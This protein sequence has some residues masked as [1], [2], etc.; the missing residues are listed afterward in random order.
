ME[1]A[2][3]RPVTPQQVPLAVY[4]GDTHHWT[5]TV[6][7]ADGQPIDLT[8]ATGRAEIRARSGGTVLAD[9]DCAV[10]LPN[11]IELLL[12]ADR[13]ATLPGGRFGWDLQLMF[14]DDTVRTIV[15]GQV[16]VT[17]DITDSVPA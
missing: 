1:R 9:I 8:G 13:S 12:P 7:A 14:G 2:A 6:W 10:T 5:V 4:C 11:T 3:G 15:A 17:A 16:T